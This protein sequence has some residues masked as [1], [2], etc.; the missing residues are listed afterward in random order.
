[1]FLLL[2]WFVDVITQVFGRKMEREVGRYRPQCEGHEA[3]HSHRIPRSWRYSCKINPGTLQ[4]DGPLFEKLEYG[5]R[6]LISVTRDDFGEGHL[7]QK[8]RAE[9]TG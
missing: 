4:K 9:Y 1:M 2:E 6:E 8:H 3:R 5:D 7:E